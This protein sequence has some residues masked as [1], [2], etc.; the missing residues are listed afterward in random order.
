MLELQYRLNAYKML[1]VEM[2][3]PGPCVDA[4]NLEHLI[5]L[6]HGVEH[7]PFE[8]SASG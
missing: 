6:L 5:H 4:S 2:G 8:D 7:K 3:R 1:V